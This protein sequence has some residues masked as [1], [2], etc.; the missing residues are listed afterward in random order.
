MS[1]RSNIAI[2]EKDGK[3]KV[4]YCHFDGYYD[5]VGKTL[6]EHYNSEKL[7]RQIIETGD[8]SSLVDNP[9]ELAKEAYKDGNPARTYNSVKEYNDALRGDVWIEFVYMWDVESAG[10]L[11]FYHTNTH[12]CKPRFALLEDMVV[13]EKEESDADELLVLKDEVVGAID[14]MLAKP[15]ENHSDHVNFMRGQLEA[16]EPKW[17][18]YSDKELR[19]ALA[20]EVIEAWGAEVEE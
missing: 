8:F 6:L 7:A 4:V 1:T 16:H 20:L 2:K 17:S 19:G 10:W 9:D 15:E 3:V 5:G 11:C 13:S 18:K 12:G 14:E